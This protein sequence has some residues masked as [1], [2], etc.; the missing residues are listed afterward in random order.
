MDEKSG[1]FAIREKGL[2]GKPEF[3]EWC[4]TNL[5]EQPRET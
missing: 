1:T 5:G 3:P 2:A 4:F